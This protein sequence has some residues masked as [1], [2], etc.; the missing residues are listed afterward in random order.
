MRQGL[1][2]LI[3]SCCI[4][5]T[6]AQQ[7]VDTTRTY[8]IPEVVVTERYQTRETRA[9]VPLQIL[10]SE[11]LK[12]VG[13]MQL[14]DAVKHF[15]GVNVRDYGGIGG[16]KTVSV[17][18]LG[19][20]HTA[21][22]YDGIAVTD[23]QTGQID[24]GRFSL[25]NV[26]QIALSIG[27]SD[28]IFT[29]ARAKASSGTLSIY[30][31]TPSFQEQ[32]A[33]NLR[34]SVKAGSWK[35]VNPTLLLEQR[36][37]DKWTT[38]LNAEWLSSDGRYPYTLEYA[39]DGGL[40]TRQ[41]RNNTKVETLRT[42]LSVYGNFSDTEQLRLKAYYYQSS[43]GLPGA[44]T[45]YYDYSSQHLWDK[46][47]FVQASYKND[48]NERWALQGA[49]KW[50]WQYQHYLDPDYKGSTGQTENHYYQQEYYLTASAL[51]RALRHV[52]F[53]L[54]T[55]G[56]INRM[57][58][59]L[60]DF[61]KPIRYSWL[62]ALSAK[63]VDETVTASASLLATMIYEDALE[64]E[65]AGGHHRLS[66]FV[67]VT[68]KPLKKEELRIRAFYKDA[69]RLPS[70]N[71]L[72]YGV[73][74]SIDLKP[75][76][77]TSWNL[78]VTYSK[79]VSLWLPFI[80]LAVDAYW[81]RVSDKIVATPTKNL[82]VWSM[83][84]LGKVDIKGLDVTA[85]ASVRFAKGYSLHM[86]ANHTYQ[87]ALDVTDSDPTTAEGQT[88]KHQ[89]AYTP[90]VSGSGQA[91]LETPWVNLSYSLIYSGKR[92]MLGQNLAK[93]RIDGYA[94]HS[95]SASRSFSLGGVT[96]R[97]NVEVLNLAGKNYEIIKNFPM[98]GRSFRVTLGV[99][100]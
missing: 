40:S 42:E 31:V 92:Y 71:D 65:S 5:T 57:S 48:L 9:S 96:A 88:Y 3:L 53:S 45:Y 30:T 78:G 86:T 28:N 7:R 99:E 39:S 91:T 14:S 55:D 35:L 90:R 16:L 73:T 72:Y 66:P 27:Q 59:D 54:A 8:K 23:C 37:S 12:S 38:S 1:V 61:A 87:R 41:E 77:A 97:V 52:S 100:I 2:T 22:T 26:D 69:F 67:S 60:V 19:A 85:H 51:Y 70:F 34:A 11:S 21:V 18:S 17:R 74:G 24:L 13:A 25:E 81:N 49:A 6:T 89:I 29:P 98:P 4:A 75:E 58:S 36:L 62:T 82:F 33:T 46:N 43:R 15:A 68:V 94:D 32:K 79:E 83:V 44:T 95:I 10:T 50:N 64:G 47:A 20:Q 76:R 80:S 56:I 93:N 63:Y 84:N